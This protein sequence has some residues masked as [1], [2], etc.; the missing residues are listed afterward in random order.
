[1]TTDR[2]YR[3]A[4]SAQEALDE[5]RRTEGPQ[6]DR[7]IVEKFIQHRAAKNADHAA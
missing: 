1:M 2:P 6:L 3:K 5:L 4:M 7:E